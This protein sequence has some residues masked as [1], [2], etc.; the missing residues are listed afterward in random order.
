MNFLQVKIHTP[1]ILRLSLSMMIMS[2]EMLW[3]I[4]LRF[5]MK[6]KFVVSFWKQVKNSKR[7]T[8][9]PNDRVQDAWKRWQKVSLNNGWITLAL[10]CTNIFFC[11]W[12][13]FYANISWLRK[14]VESHVPHDILHILLN[15]VLGHNRGI[16]STPRKQEIQNARRQ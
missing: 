9:R 12:S 11:N 3:T 7:Y 1:Y 6:W 15:T 2:I 5:K 16:G 4:C 8:K 14:Y 10:W 13:F